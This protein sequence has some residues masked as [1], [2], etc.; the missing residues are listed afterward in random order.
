MTLEQTVAQA[1]LEELQKIAEGSPAGQEKTAAGGL[2]AQLTQENVLAFLKEAGFGS[3]LAGV[4]RG[5]GALGAGAARGAGGLVAG[6][7]RGVGGAVSNAVQS[8]VGAVKGVPGALG[9]RMT[10]WGQK[11]EQSLG[12]MGARLQQAGQAKGQAVQ[13]RLAGPTG[14][15]A[16]KDIAMHQQ[17]NAP[18]GSTAGYKPPMLSA[19][20]QLGASN[21]LE[22]MGASLMA[23]AKGLLQRAPQTAPAA[24]PQ[25]SAGATYGAGLAP[26]M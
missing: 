3:M 4:G 7:A 26:A 1:F 13:G 25:A 24:A 16:L 21:P 11:A 5:L 6:A 17:A 15:Q 10:A 2:A 20:Q 23:G 18:G 8:G 9:A 22:G 14:G 12:G 19:G